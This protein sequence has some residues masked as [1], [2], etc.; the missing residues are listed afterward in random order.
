MG[1]LL[2]LLFINDITT[3]EFSG[4]SLILY[5]D[6]ILLYRAIQS[7]T[8]YKL[9]QRD[10]D[11]LYIWS[12]E[13]H[14]CFNPTKCKYLIISRKCNPLR[15]TVNLNINNTV[16]SKVDHIRYLGVWIT[17]NLS[18]SK[19]IDVICKN[20]RKKLGFMY[21]LFYQHSSLATL[22]ELY[23]SCVRSQLEYACPVWDPHLR[24]AVA[25]LEK[26]QKFALRLCTKK[27]AHSNYSSLLEQCYLPT[28]ETRRLYLKLCYLYQVIN[29]NFTFPNAPLVRCALP[30]VLRNAGSIRLKRQYDCTPILLFPIHNI[31]MEHSP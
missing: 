17:E 29:G 8:D 16:L 2:F 14:L 6:D 19:H 13:N 20:A 18:W 7:D 5:A 26:V 3:L 25:A 27:W 1:S 21:R 30:P 15:P 10:I 28:L 9:L 24:T 22:K 12:E 23:I 4:G 11:K 31:K